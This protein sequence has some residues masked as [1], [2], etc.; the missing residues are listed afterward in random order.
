MKN[1][2]V[3]SSAFL[4]LTSSLVFTNFAKKAKRVEEQRTP[5]E[6]YHFTQPNAGVPSV[7][8]NPLP[9]QISGFQAIAWRTRTK[10][11]TAQN[12]YVETTI[13]TYCAEADNAPSGI[14]TVQFQ[15]N[16]GGTNRSQGVNAW[17]SVQYG[18]NAKVSFG[19]ML[20]IPFFT[21]PYN[22]ALS[23]FCCYAD[24]YLRGYD[25]VSQK[26]Y[27]LQ[28]A[29]FDS[30]GIPGDSFY[31]DVFTGEWML[32]GTLRNSAYMSMAPTSNAFT[33]TTFSPPLRFFGAT[34]SRNQ[35]VAILTQLKA[36][37]GGNFSTN[38]DDQRIFAFGCTPEIANGQTGGCMNFR[39]N[40]MYLR[41]EY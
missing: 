3:L 21:P 22:T 19:A 20:S 6:A 10:F 39:M 32:V 5:A 31:K 15:K 38:P 12:N 25:M 23:P 40:N 8:L 26:S 14:V 30:R 35:M 33:S 29:F 28:F 36:K 11:V 9:A 2:I 27:W 41:T 13:N 24:F 4:V 17:N 34:I 7:V 18:N 16:W 1:L 37:I